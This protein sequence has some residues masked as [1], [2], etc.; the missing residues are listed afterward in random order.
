MN[1]LAPGRKPEVSAAILFVALLAMS[2]AVMGKNLKAMLGQ[3]PDAVRKLAE[4][5]LP[6]LLGG[7][8]WRVRSR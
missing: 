3:E 6:A 8:R 5:L 2:D 7:R 4:R 1:A